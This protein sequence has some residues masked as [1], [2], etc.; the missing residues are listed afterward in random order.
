[1]YNPSLLRWQ[2]YDPDWKQARSAGRCPLVHCLL[3]LIL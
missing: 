3:C 1:M 2:G